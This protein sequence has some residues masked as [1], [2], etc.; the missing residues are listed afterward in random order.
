MI[1]PLIS[2]VAINGQERRARS[3][4]Q[5]KLIGI[6]LALVTL[7]WSVFGRTLGHPFVA[8]DDPTY[9]Y[10]NQVVSA[11]LTWPGFVAA[12]TQCQARNWHPLTT[13]SHMLDCQLFGLDAAGHH[14][15]NVLLH[16]VA[17]LLLFAVL[18]AATGRWCLSAFVAAIF[19]IHPLRAESVA[20][21]AERKDVLS[22]VFFMLT[23]GAY[24][25]H[26]LRP[27]I[28]TYLLFSFFF[29]LGLLSK[30]MLVTLPFLLLLLDYWPLARFGGTLSTHSVRDPNLPKNPKCS[31]RQL[32]L[33]KIPL[34]CLSLGAALITFLAQR[35]TLSYTDQ[36]PPILR[37][38][39]A[40]VTY[41]TYIGQM[42][43][44]ANLA[45]FYPQPSSLGFWP[46]F[47]SVLLL[48]AITAIA[49][50]LRRD[51]PYLL[52]G[53]F[54]YLIA[55]LPVIGLVQVGLQARAD[56]YTYLP[57]IGLCLAL[58]CAVA[59]LPIWTNAGRRSA[60]AFAAISVVAALAWQA[61]RQTSY[62]R[63]TEML[64]THAAAVTANNDVAHYN[65]G[66]IFLERG[67]WDDAIWHYEQALAASDDRESHSHMSA[68]LVHNN[69]A[70]A[71]ARN[72][73]FEEAATHLRRAIELRDDFADAH[74]N[75]GAM[76]ARKG[77]TAGAI[78][79]Y[80]KA[81]RVPPEDA[82]SHL[83]LAALLWRIGRKDEALAHY[84][85]ALQIAPG[86]VPKLNA[87]SKSF[88]PPVLT[89]ASVGREAAPRLGANGH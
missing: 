35:H 77:D 50:R 89:A 14:F 75:L 29:A 22:A 60:L 20:W 44:P 15:T 67:Q 18:R 63:S 10:E 41:V 53:W 19:A 54:W 40:A 83:S 7:T 9:V 49:F 52:V 76:L 65:L 26:A 39:H 33:E 78:I 8:Y 66:A 21:V 23:L 36:T 27:T 6:Y 4:D 47:L 1:A 25:R 31:P 56:R 62:W 82:P 11:G 12:F 3:F 32:I 80:E 72:G 46:I 42:F 2:E 86:S 30:P 43:W 17:V 34:L 85:R 24:F 51:R 45:A 5:F 87:L 64:W 28:L 16:T 59:S 69:L 48:V 79:H 57:Q 74:A 13:L 55:L 84:R 37:F 71:L 73:R 58:S 70:I 81:L 61:G 38:G 88:D 68:A